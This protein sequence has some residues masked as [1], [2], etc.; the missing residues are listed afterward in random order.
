MRIGFSY[1]KQFFLGIVLENGNK[2]KIKIKIKMKNENKIKIKNKKS[3]LQDD[4]VQDN[5]MQDRIFFLILT[6]P[7]WGGGGV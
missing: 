1:Q 2:N 3:I 7:P 6:P 5:R 4:A